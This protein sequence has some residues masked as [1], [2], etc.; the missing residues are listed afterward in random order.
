MLVV[1]LQYQVQVLLQSLQMEVV[2]VE[3]MKL[4]LQPELMDQVLDQVIVIQQVTQEQMELPLKDLMVE[5]LLV[6]DH[7]KE[8]LVVVQVQMDQMVVHHLL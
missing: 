3:N 6:V 2:V 4:L 7:N 5:I 8:V 1:F